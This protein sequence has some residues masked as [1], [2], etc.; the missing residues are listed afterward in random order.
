VLQLR[1]EA[2]ERQVQDAGV[3]VAQSWRGVPTTT[4]AVA[5]FASE[6]AAA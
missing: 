4:A 6:E 5:V 2:G 3:A 1:G